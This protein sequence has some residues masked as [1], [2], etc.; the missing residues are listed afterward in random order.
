MIAHYSA[1]RS[2]G[3]S[4]RPLTSPQRC[5]PE[6][7]RREHN[8]P[9]RWP[10]FSLYYQSPKDNGEARVSVRVSHHLPKL[11]VRGKA[12]YLVVTV[13]K[14]SE[15]VRQNAS[16]VLEWKLATG[17]GNLY[18]LLK[19]TGCSLQETN[20]QILCRWKMWDEKTS[21]TADP[22]HWLVPAHAPRTILFWRTY[23]WL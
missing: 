21:I 1:V 6:T 9:R 17:K 14:V 5:T 10:A 12:G 8:V 4:F 13:D 20:H 3:H 19:V 2:E 23:I 18:V 16:A 7:R 22:N 11:L 15:L